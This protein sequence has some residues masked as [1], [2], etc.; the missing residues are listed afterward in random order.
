M[1]YG[2]IASTTIHL[3]KIQENVVICPVILSVKVGMYLGAYL[4]NNFMLEGLSQ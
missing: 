1:L 2:I 3:D 4:V